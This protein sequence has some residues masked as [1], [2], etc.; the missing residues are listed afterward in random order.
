MDSPDRLIK[1]FASSPL[2]RPSLSLSA[3]LNQ[4]SKRSTSAIATCQ[5]RAVSS[6]LQRPAPMHQGRS[7]ERWAVLLRK[8]EPWQELMWVP[9]GIPPVSLCSQRQPCSD[10]IDAQPSRLGEAGR[11]CDVIYGLVLSCRCT[12]CTRVCLNSRA[13]NRQEHGGRPRGLGCSALPPCP[14]GQGLDSIE[15]SQTD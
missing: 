9:R 14:N 6:T 2:I 10:Q 13:G 7:N 11:S 1:S 8:R 5:G 15:L 4:L 12:R 3:S